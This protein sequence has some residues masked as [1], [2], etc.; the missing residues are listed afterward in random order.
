MEVPF[1]KRLPPPRL[2]VAPAPLYR[3]VIGYNYVF[4]SGSTKGEVVVPILAAFRFR[5]L[6]YIYNFR[7]RNGVEATSIA[8]KIETE[9]IMGKES[10]NVI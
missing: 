5:D 1:F 4:L 3:T 2:T 6:E 9:V 7:D 10:F 8:Q